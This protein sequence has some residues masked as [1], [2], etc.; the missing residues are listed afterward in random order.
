MSRTISLAVWR[1][2]ACVVALA[3][4]SVDAGVIR[5]VESVADPH[6]LPRPARD[7]AHVPPDTS[8]YFKLA[9]DAEDDGDAIDLDTIRVAL[10]A[11]DASGGEDRDDAAI[12]LLEPGQRFADGVAGWVRRV[13]VGD[14]AGAAVYLDPG[15]TLE[16]SATYTVHVAAESRGGL[17]FG[18]GEPLYQPG[19]MVFRARGGRTQPAGPERWRFTSAPDPKRIERRIEFELDLGRD[20]VEWRGRFFSGFC[21]VQ[22]VTERDVYGPTY[23]LMEQARARHPRAWSFQ[24]DF[25]LTG[26]EHRTTTIFSSTLPNIVREAETRRITAIE[27]HARDTLLRVETPAD[28]ERYGVAPGRSL[29]GDY[30]PGYTVLIADGH[31]DARAEVITADD[32]AGTVLVSEIRTPEGGWRLDH[33][34]ADADADDALLAGGAYLLR[35]DPHGTTVY[36]WDR[37][38]HEWDMVVNDYDRRVMPN[39]VDAAGCLSI[40][41]RTGAAPK[42]Y[43]QWHDA[44]RTITGRIIDRYGDASL[45]FVWSVFNEPD[46][47]RHWLDDWSELPRFYDYTVDAI[48]RAFEDRG[49]DSRDV[50]VGGL[51]LGAIF[52]T[53]MRLE[54]FLEHCSPDHAGVNHAYAD[55]RL[56]GE[57][58]QRVEALTAANNGRGSPLD[59]LS[60]H[61]YNRSDTAADKLISAKRVALGIDADHYE[62]L[63]INSHEACPD[64]APPRD[65][66]ARDAYL[67]NGYF[68]TWSVDLVARQLR[69]ADADPR[70]AYGETIMTVWPPLDHFSGLNAFTRRVRVDRTGDGRADERLTVPVPAFHLIT[71]L[72][73]FHERFHVLPERVVDGQAVSGF[74]SPG[75]DGVLRVMLYA[76]HAG[77]T[78]SRSD[79]SFEI[80]LRVAGLDAADGEM[81]VTEYRFDRAHN[82]YFEFAQ[83]R[84]GREGGD[85]ARLRRILTTLAEGD[86]DDQAAALDALEA[87]AAE[88]DSQILARVA[89]FAR[90]ADERELRE[91]A[92]T[93][94]DADLS[95]LG[96][97]DALSPDEARELVSLAE[98]QVTDERV[99]MGDGDALRLRVPLIGNGA[100]VLHIEPATRGR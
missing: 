32:D 7:A 99:V 91:H 76:H 93:L 33:T 95:R 63:W 19:P 69:Q 78:Q 83:A 47:N 97:D 43:A 12:L 80:D 68:K 3:C 57:R 85:D 61:I 13:S 87:L 66:A 11:E 89:D 53:N 65:P 50:F 25:W 21:N 54:D 15:R 74:A 75:D 36:H 40:N 14:A 26:T 100:T 46:L 56:E 64:W 41:G 98:L 28:H 27:P 39:F 44:V 86:A 48:L 2:L 37:L 20:A 62:S 24:R 81:R 34:R 45:D 18:D 1:A 94:A 38:D 55:D 23:E 49:Y 42:D 96:G 4:A 52:G 16:P 29:T 9:L 73:D 6:G 59:F 8:L 67:G 90:G 30:E 17:T 22:F 60:I 72:S 51:E 84:I 71:L 31:H 5:M 58:S 70:Y 35:F 92:R 79:A 10:R 88:T 82:S 77:D